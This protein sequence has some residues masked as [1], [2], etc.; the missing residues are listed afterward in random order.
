VTTTRTRDDPP[1][2]IEGVAVAILWFLESISIWTIA[3]RTTDGVIAE[4]GLG[5]RCAPGNDDKK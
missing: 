4:K 1:H 3:I 2:R 5:M